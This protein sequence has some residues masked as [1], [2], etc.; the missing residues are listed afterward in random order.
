MP[1]VWHI[2]FMPDVQ[3]K[4]KYCL[5]SITCIKIVLLCRNETYTMWVCSDLRD[6]KQYDYKMLD[7]MFK[8]TRQDL[9]DY[10][11]VIV[12]AKQKAS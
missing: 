8:G 1:D 5:V 10:S 9:A 3:V 12:V 6:D 11:D 4:Y 7:V 2:F